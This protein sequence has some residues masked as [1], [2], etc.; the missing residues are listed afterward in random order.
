M[1]IDVAQL[2]ELVLDNTAFLLTHRR[3]TAVQAIAFQHPVDRDRRRYRVVRFAQDG[4]NLITVH[5]PLAMGDDL[6]LDPFRLASSPPFRP[7]PPRQ[8]VRF[9][10]ALQIAIVILAER[11]R[12]GP[13]VP[14]KV[15]DPLEQRRS[16]SLHRLILRNQKTP[17]V[18]IVA[19]NRSVIAVVS[20]RIVPSL[21]RSN[22]RISE[23]AQQ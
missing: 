13:V 10:A 16:A 5:P 7:A 11:L 12:A 17:L 2:S 23:H 22:Q 3:R 18:Q 9:L 20:H 1:Q 21:E 6:R 15:A 19:F 4:M 8:Q 14:V